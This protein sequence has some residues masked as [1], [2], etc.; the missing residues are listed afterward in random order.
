ME[1]RREEEEL[2]R[3]KAEE[4]QR[5]AEEERKAREKALE[6]ARRKKLEQVCLF[7]FVIAGLIC[8]ICKG[9]WHRLVC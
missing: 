6:E 7:G 3:K 8:C 4:A 1:K 9:V 5:K 2:A